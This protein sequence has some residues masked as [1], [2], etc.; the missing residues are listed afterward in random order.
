MA[1]TIVICDVFCIP[2]PEESGAGCK[3]R[4][5]SRIQTFDPRFHTGPA[6]G[7]GYIE[8]GAED[9]ISIRNNYSGYLRYT[10]RP[11]VLRDV[12]ETDLTTTILQGRI[13]IKFP[14]C[15]SPFA[16]Y[17]VLQL[18][19]PQLFLELGSLPARCF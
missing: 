19:A 2:A 6:L 9:E 14:V 18:L 10:L 12:A 15:V 7:N 16:G 3:T 8:Y 4:V 1:P 5:G 17:A 11:R 13:P